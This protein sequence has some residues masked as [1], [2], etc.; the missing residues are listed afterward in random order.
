M[1]AVEPSEQ[2]F[3]RVSKAR[4]EAHR[5]HQ[6]TPRLPS[7][8]RGQFPLLVGECVCRVSSQVKY[9]HIDESDSSEEEH[10]AIVPDLTRMPQGEGL[11]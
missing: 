6:L 9:H 2:R 11:L 5:R 1:V 7:D 10:E 8:F 3:P 4:W